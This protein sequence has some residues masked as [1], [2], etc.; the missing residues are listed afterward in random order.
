M[1]MVRFHS[2]KQLVRLIP[3]LSLDVVLWL[4]MVFSHKQIL[5]PWYLLSLTYHFESS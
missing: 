1:H 3:F 2:R 5:T 4:Y